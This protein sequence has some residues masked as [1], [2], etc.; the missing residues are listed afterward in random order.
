MAKNKKQKKPIST[1][2]KA[3]RKRSSTRLPCICSVQLFDCDDGQLTPRITRY[4]GILPSSARLRIVAGT[5]LTMII[6]NPLSGGT[7][8]NPPV[9]SG[10]TNGGNG[11]TITAWL[12]NVNGKVT[13]ANLI[14][15]QNPPDW[16]ATFPDVALGTYYLSVQAQLDNETA[17]QTIQVIIVAP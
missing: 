8:R 13:K 3:P 7:E 16:S 10:T 17:C 6:D 14:N 11:T 2:K 5:S 1:K 9:A 12:T 15:F 4:L